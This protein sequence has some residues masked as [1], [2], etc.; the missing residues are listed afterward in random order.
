MSILIK[1]EARKAADRSQL[2]SNHIYD[3]KS[4][5]D[6][7]VEGVHYAM[8][9]TALLMDRESHRGKSISFWEMEKSI[10]ECNAKSEYKQSAIH[11]LRKAY[12]SNTSNS[13]H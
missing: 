5:E 3:H 2:N 10:R 4:Y 11:L 12:E 13:Q 7:F 8:K 1:V 9:H 6:G